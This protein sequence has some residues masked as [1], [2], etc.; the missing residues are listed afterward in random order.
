MYMYAR[1]NYKQRSPILSEH[2]LHH[3]QWRRQ[4][5]EEG[6]PHASALEFLAGS[7]TFL[8][9][10]LRLAHDYE[11]CII[12][13]FACKYQAKSRDKHGAPSPLNLQARWKLNVQ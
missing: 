5:L 2:E 1:S 9:I 3:T 10:L 4:D 13:R 6:E 11:T 12:H 7:H 8:C